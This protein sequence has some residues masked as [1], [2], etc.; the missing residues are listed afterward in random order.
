MA[1]TNPIPWEVDSVLH[2]KVPLGSPLT[3]SMKYRVKEYRKRKHPKTCPSKVF[4]FSIQ[5]RMTKMTRPLAASY[6][7]VGCSGTFSLAR[8]SGL[9]K[10]TAQGREV[11]VP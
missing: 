5:S 7:W 9:V 1:K 11:S 6:S 10:T 3:I 4:L 8:E 2:R